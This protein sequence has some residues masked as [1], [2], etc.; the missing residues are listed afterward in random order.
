V[1]WR[2]AAV[3][4]IRTLGPLTVECDGAAVRL[5]GHK[6]RA[7][8]ACL[9]T[10]PNRIM[11][12]DRVAEAVWGDEPPDRAQG[13]VQV[14]VSSLRR[15]LEPLKAGRGGREL[16]VTRRP[17]YV[18]EVA[19]DELD[20]LAFDALVGE[21]RQLAGAG[22]PAD[23]VARYQDADRLWRGPVLADLAD[24]PFVRSLAT[25]L[26]ATRQRAREERL[27]LDLALGR[28]GQVLEELED[29]VSRQPLNER[30]RELLMLALYRDGRQADALAAYREGRDALVD[31][32]GLEPSAA[33]RT[34]EHRILVQDPS[35]DLGADRS[36][37]GPTVMHS[38]V[39]IPSA[40]VQIGERRVLLSRP[41]TTIG[42]RRDRDIVV[43][44]DDVSRTHA[45]IRTAAGGFV[46]VD[47][48]S[49]NGTHANGARI[50][51]HV[52]SDGDE[53]VVGRSR[54]RFQSG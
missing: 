20:H 12:V 25:R 46:L 35:L 45:E 34:M 13:I 42:R 39:Q 23:A 19:A 50:T 48:G 28:H 32:L 17:G 31:E 14:Y 53:I 54:L 1:D 7:V 41:V 11:S 36:A 5:G 43:A 44:D 37:E 16:I 24:E 2:D 30:L 22:V 3:T 8:F 51:E 26:E 4:A 49:T 18:V 15:A 6:Q 38:S 40:Y 47:T 29:L 52:L 33:L 9:L 21:A 10:E 27:E